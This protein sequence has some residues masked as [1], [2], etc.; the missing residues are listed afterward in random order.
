MNQKKKIIICLGAIVLCLVAYFVGQANRPVG[1]GTV[2]VGTASISDVTYEFEEEQERAG[3]TIGDNIKIPGYDLI[4]VDAGETKIKG[5]FF[6][7]DEN[8]V[9]FKM[10]FQLTE[11]EEIIFASDLIK[12]GQHLYEIELMRVLDAGEYDLTILYETF[13]TD[14]NFTPLNGANLQCPLQV[15]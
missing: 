6:N 10:V 12:P 7:P 4:A 11:T 9:Y 14:G 1:T 3:A 2:S 8:N 13:S 15:G 5:D